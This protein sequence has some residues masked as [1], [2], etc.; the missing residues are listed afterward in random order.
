MD[1][2][3][4][5]SLAIVSLLYWHSFSQ[6]VLAIAAQFLLFYICTNEGCETSRPSIGTEA[7]RLPDGKMQQRE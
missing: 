2:L 4:T 3:A 5:I 6:R 7:L 1:L